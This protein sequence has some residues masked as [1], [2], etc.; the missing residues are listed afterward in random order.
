MQQLIFIIVTVLSF[1]FFGYTVFRILSYFKLTK[2]HAYPTLDNIGERITHTLLVAFGQSKILKKPVAGLLHALVYWGFLVITVGTL[3]MI[4]DGLFGTQRILSRLGG[5]YDVVTISGEVFAA[6]IIISCVIF[7]IRRYIVKPKRFTAPE[8]KP[9]SRMDAT[10]ILSMILLLMFSLLGMNIGYLNNGGEIHG[11]FP[12]SNMF[13]SS[14]AGMNLHTFEIVN[15]WIHISLV[16]IFLNVL[17]YSKHFHVILAVPNVF[18]E[19]LGPKGRL[20]SMESVTKEVKLMMNPDTAFAP[21]PEGEQAEIPRFGVKDIEDVSWKTLMD[22]YTC[23][24]CGR[25]TDV[26]P[27][28]ITGKLLSPR[29]LYIDARQRMKDKGDALIKDPNYSDGKSLIGDYITEEELWA[30][31]TCGACMEECPVDINH[32]PFII[33]MRRSLVMEESKAPASLNMMMTNIENNGAPWQ[34]SAADRM[35]WTEELYTNDE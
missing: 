7:L 18:L 25:C 29:K 3:E 24:E 2:E 26:C 31:T 16:F 12:I 10:V 14:I 22:S 11:S 33:D 21:P 13:A 6:L 17:P 8:M 4:I 1:G 23:T 19:R 27:A 28:N 30:C 15:W 32:V 20:N 35:K 34:F 5:I 9:S